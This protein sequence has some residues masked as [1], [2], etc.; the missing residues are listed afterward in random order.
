MAGKRTEDGFAGAKNMHK[1]R[2]KYRSLAIT[3][4]EHRRPLT[5]VRHRPYC[6]ETYQTADASDPLNVRDCL[7]SLNLTP[8]SYCA[9]VAKFMIGLDWRYAMSPIPLVL[10]SYGPSPFLELLRLC[11]EWFHRL[12]SRRQ[13]HEQGH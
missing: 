2:L 6:P 3:L 8:G 13:R 4:T 11:F 9:L 10:C 12:N 1:E 5:V 7:V